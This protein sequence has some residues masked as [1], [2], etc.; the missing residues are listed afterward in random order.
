[1]ST[2]PTKGSHGKLSQAQQAH[3][4]PSPTQAEGPLAVFNALEVGSFLVSQSDPTSPIASTGASTGKLICGSERTTAYLLVKALNALLEKKK[5]SKAPERE[6]AEP[7]CLLQGIAYPLPQVNSMFV[8]VGLL[9]DH[10]LPQFWTL[11]KPIE[12]TVSVFDTL[13]EKLRFWIVHRDDIADAVDS[14]NFESLLQD[15]NT[16]PNNAN[17]VRLR[18][19]KTVD[20]KFLRD[21][22]Y[23]HSLK[24]LLSPAEPWSSWYAPRLQLYHPSLNDAIRGQTELGRSATIDVQ[25]DLLNAFHPKGITR[26]DWLLLPSPM[27]LLAQLVSCVC[28]PDYSKLLEEPAFQSMPVK[29]PSQSAEKDSTAETSTK[30]KTCKFRLSARAKQDLHESILRLS[31]F[32]QKVP[33]NGTG[34][35]D[36]TRKF[37][38]SDG[39][40]VTD[41]PSS[42]DIIDEVHDNVAYGIATSSHDYTDTRYRPV[43]LGVKLSA[44]QACGLHPELL[45]WCREAVDLFLTH[46]EDPE[47]S[48]YAV[49]K[50]KLD[51]I[52]AQLTQKH[53]QGY[54]AWTS[55]RLDIESELLKKMSQHAIENGTYPNELTP[56]TQRL[57]DNW[58]WEAC[59]GL[60]LGV[61][62]QDNEIR[63]PYDW[64]TPFLYAP[65]GWVCRLSSVTRLET[66]STKERPKTEIDA[67]IHQALQS[68]YILVNR[69]TEEN[70][71]KTCAFESQKPFCPLAVYDTQE[72]AKKA[73]N[74]IAEMSGEETPSVCL[75]QVQTTTDETSFLFFHPLANALR[76]MHQPNTLAL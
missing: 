30:A 36:L 50:E 70:F 32:V 27:E 67:F 56:P 53:S 49:E 11:D 63:P 65:P 45:R 60:T 22:D 57:D 25:P 74:A 33:L 24:P 43:K 69:I 7:T 4:L 48:Q 13:C 26:P 72:D 71:G 44:H 68:K 14:E 41:E 62:I 19:S 9:Q 58:E 2:K 38:A 46:M 21:H 42:L 16:K 47:P 20:L 75:L 29:E 8:I 59:A 12:L 39:T 23:T 54:L 40:P 31:F 28:S 73:L 15:T 1:M 18:N 35:W 61:Q 5:K 76:F 55:V 10:H 6:K 51:G 17:L 37:A 34:L 64:M 3:A 52:R 66:T